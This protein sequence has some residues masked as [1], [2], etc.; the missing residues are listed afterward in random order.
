MKLRINVLFIALGILVEMTPCM[1]QN[2]QYLSTFEIV[3]KKVNETYYDSTFGG[4]NWKDAHNRYIP[5][6]TAAEKDEDFYRLVNNMLWE[7]KVSHTNLIRPGNLARSEPLVCAEGSPGFDI[8]I[9]DGLAVV[10]YVKPGSPANEAGLR[11]GY[12]IQAVDEIPVGQIIQEAELLMR[13]PYNGPSRI[14]IITKAILSRIY[15]TPGTEVS[16]AY[17]D[18][19]GQKSEK[20]LM[21]TKRS[22][23]AVGPN[24]ILFLAVDF[25]ARRM[26]NGIGYIR[27]NTFQQP[28]A[29]QISNAIK[30]MGNV[31]AII[32]D[33]RGNSGGE[34]EEMPDLFLNERA[35][36]YLRRSRNGETKMFFDPA[37]D[38]YKGPLV[39]LIDQLSGSACELFAG[40]LQAIGR[41]VV[42]GERSPGAVTESDM[43]I[44]PNGAIFMYP[45]AQLATPDGTVLEGHGV[46]PD[47]EVGLEREMLLMGVDSQINS[48]IRYIEKE[49]LRDPPLLINVTD[50]QYTTLH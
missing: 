36:L 2:N 38:V 35:L 22:G 14:A 9:L 44:F 23:V 33:L 42:V 37:N 21:R 45:V 17:S 13:P 50:R 25:E 48:A 32:F 24:G 19:R 7:L 6:I 8:R 10:T 16:I 41:A 29:P 43:M 1:S 49:V 39:L 20:I 4:F 30:S 27:L 11:P 40:S 5:Q 31:S 12:V 28:L 26:D 3:W 47:L 34:I 46:V 15:G 18:E